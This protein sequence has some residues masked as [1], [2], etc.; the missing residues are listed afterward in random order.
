MLMI[1]HVQLGVIQIH[2]ELEEAAAIAGARQANLRP[3]VVRR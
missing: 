2:P 1:A 3:R